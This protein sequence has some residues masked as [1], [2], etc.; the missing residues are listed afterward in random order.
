MQLPLMSMLDS[1]F[2]L[3][4]RR[5]LLL[6]LNQL[7]IRNNEITI[8]RITT[9]MSMVRRM[10]NVN[11]DQLIE[12]SMLSNVS[13]WVNQMQR[14]WKSNLFLK[15]VIRIN[16]Q[17]LTITT[18]TATT[19]FEIDQT[20]YPIEVFRFFFLIWDNVFLLFSFRFCI[21]LSSIGFQLC[22]SSCHLF[23]LV[24]FSIST[25]SFK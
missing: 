23:I 15:I 20:V 4:H 1:K 21:F 19:S 18:T 6:L 24:Y 17:I 10:T 16:I 12:F 8:N 14:Q 5:L 13:T 7:T 3:H 11:V 25:S 2:Q 9:M 22:F